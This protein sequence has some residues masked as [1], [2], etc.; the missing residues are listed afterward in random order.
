MSEKKSDKILI[1]ADAIKAYIGVG[2]EHLF[3]KFLNAKLPVV[4]IDN[5]L[6]AHTDNLD[7]YFQKLTMQQRVVSSKD[8]AKNAEQEII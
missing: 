1:G 4:N 3:K 8:I 5:R 2:S 7:A 6:Y